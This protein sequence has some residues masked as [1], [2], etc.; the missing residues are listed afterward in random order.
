MRRKLEIL[1]IFLALACICHAYTSSQ[2]YVNS[3]L[4]FYGGD[5][6]N[7]TYCTSNYCLLNRTCG[8]LV[9]SD[10]VYGGYCHSTGVCKASIYTEFGIYSH[11]T[12]MT[13]IGN[14]YYPNGVASLKIIN[15]SGSI[16]SSFP[17]NVSVNSTGSFVYDY[18]VTAPNGS[19]TIIGEEILHH[20]DYANKTV[21]IK[22]PYRFYGRIINPFNGTVPSLIYVYYNGSRIAVANEVY[23]LLF[24]YGKKYDIIIKPSIPIEIRQLLVHWIA[25]Q[26]QV[27]DMMGFDELP[28]TGN[29][30]KIDVFYPLITN[31][32]DIVLTFFYP[33]NIKLYKCADWNFTERRCSNGNWTLVGAYNGTETNIT[34]HPGDPGLGIVKT[35]AAEVKK[36]I[37]EENKKSSYVS[38]GIVKLGELNEALLAETC[39]GTNQNFF[40]YINNKKYVARQL[41]FTQNSSTVEINDRIYVLKLGEIIKI[42]IDG[43]GLNDMKINFE[44]AKYSKSCYKFY[45][46]REISGNVT[47]EAP[48]K[49]TIQIAAIIIQS[50]NYLPLL[51]LAI[52]LAIIFVYVYYIFKENK[53]EQK[54]IVKKKL[55]KKHKKK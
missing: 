7:N 55:K 31:Y 47:E 44:N 10:C 51:I 12:K 28:A 2:L 40:F 26:G 1:T 39:L 20:L 53:K 45:E 54:N 4:K 46:L 5:C 22:S 42:D 3:T 27:T 29:Y 43:N 15:S 16:I 23:D 6:I 36:I 33:D 19:Y 17:I 48:M 13:I 11:N 30:S 24:D 18:V 14:N 49:K 35:T 32:E 8:C 52:L 34:F 9:D 38:G 21:G 50:W 37:E 25:N 41:N